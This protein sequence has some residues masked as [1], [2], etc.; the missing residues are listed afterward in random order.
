M[1][2]TTLLD[3]LILALT[4]LLAGCASPS[5]R[6]LDEGMGFLD[7]AIGIFEQHRGSEAE[8]L[9]A[10]KAYVAE[11]R[12]AFRENT[13]Q[14]RALLDGMS[15]E[16]RAAFVARAKERLEPRMAKI[17]ALA[18]AYPGKVEMLALVSSFNR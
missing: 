8:I 2:R 3:G 14:G 5:E 12:A 7:D 15:A 10:L 17:Q 18:A 16:E 11:H 6:L 9:A 1:A 13:R 4:L